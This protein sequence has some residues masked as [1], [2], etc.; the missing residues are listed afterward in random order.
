VADTVKALYETA[1]WR[2]GLGKQYL[3]AHAHR[4][5]LSR[6]CF[7][8]IT[9]SAGKTTT[10]DLSRLI[11]SGMAP[12]S[13]TL[14]TANT[15]D[16]IAQAVME[17]TPE[18]GYCVLELAAFKP[19]SL[20][21]PL[22]LVRPRVG[23]LTRIGRD[24]YS[25]FR[26]LDA[27][28]REKGKLIH[29]LPADGVA[30]LNA[31]D[32]HVRKVGEGC[33]CRI[34]WVGEDDNAT[35]RL[36]RSSSQWPEPLT[37]EIEYDRQRYT[38]ATGLHGRQ[39]TLSVL[40]AL[41]VALAVGLPIE[42]SIRALRDA[43]PSEGRMEVLAGQDGVVFVRD[44]WKATHWT[45]DA[46]LSFMR[47]ASAPRKVIVLGTL[48][49]SHLGPSRLY[50]RVARSALEIADVVLL[51]GSRATYAAKALTEH[52]N[53]RL[54]AIPNV[55]EAADFLKDTLRR[56]DLVLLK[57][58]NKSDH[59]IRLVMNRETPISCWK[60]DC[61]LTTFC[62]R[63]SRA[64]ADGSLDNGAGSGLMAASARPVEGGNARLPRAVPSGRLAGLVSLTGM[65]LRVLGRRVRSSAKLQGLLWKAGFVLVY[66]KAWAHR[67]RLG[68]TCFVGITGSAGKTTTKDLSQRILAGFLSVSGTRE[69]L[70]APIA[71]ARAVLAARRQD[72][73]CVVEIGAY[74]P[75]AFDRP[76]RLVDPTI[77]A[78]TL[79]GRDHYRAFKSIEAIAE[80]KSKLIAA[81]PPDGTAILNIDDPHVRKMAD[82][83]RCPIIWVGRSMGATIRLLEAHSRW[84]DPLQLT[85][86]HN[87]RAY[88]VSTKLHG[89]QL[90]LPVLT[91]L[92]ISLAAGVPL[93]KAVSRL[94]EASP[95]EGRMEVV[96]SHDGVVFLRDD[97]KAP[98]WSL[99]AP[100]A[101]LG[102]ADAP[103]KVAVLGTVSDYSG[104]STEKYKQFARKCLA[105]ADLVVFV[106][107]HAHRALRARKG[108]NEATLQGFNHI[109]DAAEYL[110][111]ELKPGDLVLVKGSHKADHLMRVVLDRD[112]PVQ[113]WRED[114]RVDIQCNQCHKVYQAPREM[115]HQPV[116][117]T[118][119]P[120]GAPRSPREPF[121][122]RAAGANAPLVIVGL[123]NPDT[124]Y[125]NT[126]HNIGYRALDLIAES[127]EGAWDD[128]EEGLVCRVHLDGTP[129]HLLKPAANM[130]VTGPRIR[131]YLESVGSDT[132]RCIIVHDD[133]DLPMG[134]VRLK[135]DGGDAGH[136]GVRSV[137]SALGTDAFARIRVGVRRPGDD[138]KA[139]HR[140]LARF[141]SDEMS[142]LPETLAMAVA[143]LREHVCDVSRREA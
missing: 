123:G 68:S 85:I 103:R 19:G 5:R 115:R 71:V 59:L 55:R 40:C 120:T 93:E 141:T 132:N 122:R 45:L 46:P 70:N 44:D 25:A 61:R 39:L 36:I 51:T 9:G 137:I 16:M 7:I 138:A 99:E 66:A 127:H 52:N 53:K 33:K 74:K 77:G 116:V 57:G 65:A 113:C 142:A 75:G 37:I 134:K 83:C 124:R 50:P 79:I 96:T 48:S 8:G 119:P 139:K 105:H 102:Q 78:V 114:C 112:R 2:L 22:R 125:D 20:D 80:E 17:T 43:A 63:C 97:I 60:N 111:G 98:A 54:F 64:R 89:E 136:R 73:F 108:A 106:G 126:P 94:A 76:L 47:D 4:L 26:S 143:L 35:I 15:P 31:D 88:Q 107:P 3:R 10:K 42:H 11:L 21:H 12:T 38:I 128:T 56:G 62:Y 82:K 130:N 140:V 84:P 18:H 104:D 86:E 121:G 109:R 92:G 91:A 1:R 23:V 58:T 135:R 49:D 72:A 133:M 117:T 95:T 29:A 67:R 14:R 41:G 87:G 129:V 27:I 100:L 6:T 13:G 24:H 81:L 101:F 90:A 34:I 28:A 118:I 131:R 30:V 32:P 69:S 110:R